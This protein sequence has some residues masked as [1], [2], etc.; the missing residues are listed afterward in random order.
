MGRRGQAGLPDRPR[1]TDD[2]VPGRSVRPGGVPTSRRRNP[3]SFRLRLGTEPAQGDGPAGQRLDIRIQRGE[4]TGGRNGFR[5][6]TD[7]L[8]VGRHGCPDRPSERCRG[9]GVLPSRRARSHHR[10]RVRRDIGAVLL[11]RRG[12][13]C[14][15]SHAGRRRRAHLQRGGPAAVRGH[16]R[17]DDDLRVRRT[18]AARRTAHTDGDRVDVDVRRGGAR[19]CSRGRRTPYVLRV[20]R[21]RPRDESPPAGWGQPHTVLG[22]QRPPLHPEPHT[23]LGARGTRR[24]AAAARVS[25]PS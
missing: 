22:R 2:D 10:D 15:G 19:R 8:R 16:R 5:R 6:A 18:G 14:P 11:R 7:P 25:L 13:S 23:C 17:Q 24:P 12:P 3:P 20:R 4:P 1:R 21:V 9:T